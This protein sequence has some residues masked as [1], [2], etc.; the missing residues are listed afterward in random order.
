MSTVLRY[1]ARRRY[2][3]IDS[4]GIAAAAIAVGRGDWLLWGIYLAIFITVS[5]IVEHAAGGRSE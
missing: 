4:I 5:K 3:A 1:L 2:N